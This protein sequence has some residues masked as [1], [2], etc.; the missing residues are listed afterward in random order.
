MRIHQLTFIVLLGVA[1]Y[2][3][4]S[5]YDRQKKELV[6]RD[7]KIARLENKLAENN[8]KA[9]GPSSNNTPTPR[10]STQK[11]ICPA[12]AGEGSLMYRP[13]AGDIQ[14]R[15]PCPVCNG[16][17]G[18]ELTLPKG[19]KLCPDCSGLGKR[20]YCSNT[21]SYCSGPNDQYRMTGRPC[22]RCS[23]HGYVQADVKSPPTP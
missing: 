9:S 10:P 23:M 19:C 15:Y 8:E 12:C 3:G 5:L 1:G 11:V 20:L 22:K 13:S 4:Y 7:E 2:Y 6:E 16:T 21:R 17:G 14:T 18:R